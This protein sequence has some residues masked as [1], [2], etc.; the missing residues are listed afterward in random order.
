MAD[1]HKFL[2]RHAMGQPSKRSRFGVGLASPSE[3][4]GLLEFREFALTWAD[5]S[6]TGDCSAADRPP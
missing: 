2:V 6:S 5:R 4:E 1:R 3:E